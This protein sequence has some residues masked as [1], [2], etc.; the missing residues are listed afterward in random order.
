[1]VFIKINANKDIEIIIDKKIK[2]KN[3][4]IIIKITCESYYSIEDIEKSGENYMKT[5]GLHLTTQICRNYSDSLGLN[6]KF[7]KE[8]NKLSAIFELQQHLNVEN[9]SDIS[10]ILLLPECKNRKNNAYLNLK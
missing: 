5:Q 7:E 3:G 1:M 9:I 6:M 4:K 2:I 10:L 8:D